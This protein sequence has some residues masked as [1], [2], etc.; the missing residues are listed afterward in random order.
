[1]NKKSL[2]VII[3]CVMVVLSSIIASIIFSMTNDKII[4]TFSSTLTNSYNKIEISKGSTLSIDKYSETAEGYEF[5]GWYTDSSLENKVNDDYIFTTNKTL[6]AGFSKIINVNQ[7]DNISSS[8]IKS[9]TIVSTNQSEAVDNKH[10]NKLLSLGVTRIDLSKAHL[11]NQ[12]TTST[13]FSNSNINEVIFGS[14]VKSLGSYTFENCYNLSNVK[15]SSSIS[16]IETGCFKNCKNLSTVKLL[17]GLLEI[18][19]DVF[20]GCSKISE[21]NIPS[22]VNNIY[23]NFVSNSSKLSRID[24]NTNNENYTSIDGVLYSKD[25]KRV[26]KCPQT[27]SGEI[28]MDSNVEIIE[29]YAFHKSNINKVYFPTSLKEIR[30]YAFYQNKNLKNIQ[31]SSVNNYLLLSSAFEDCTN[32]ET[33]KF[34]SGIQHLGHNCFKNNQSLTE[35]VILENSSFSSIGDSVFAECIKLKEISLPDSLTNI[36]VNA[37]YNC[38]RLEYVSIG[39]G[40]RE[41]ANRLFYNCENLKTINLKYSVIQ[42]GTATF[43]NCKNL[44][45]IIGI[46]YL[47]NAGQSSFYNCEKLKSISIE[48]LKSVP[49]YMFYNCK[50]LEKLTILDVRSIGEFSFAGCSSLSK[51]TFGSS[52]LEFQ[53]NSFDGTKNLTLNIIGNSLFNIVDNLVLNSD[54]TVLYHVNADSDKNEIIIPKQTS[55]IYRNAISSNHYLKNIKVDDENNYFSSNNGVLLSYNKEV[56]YSYPSGKSEELFIIPDSVKIIKKHSITSENL[57]EIIVHNNVVTIENGAMSYIPNLQT[58]TLP[59][60]GTGKQNDSQ[61]WISAIFSNSENIDQNISVNNG[62]YLPQNLKIVNITNETNISPFA[63][64]NADKIEKITYTSLVHSISDYAFA[65]CTSLT[66]IEFKGSIMSIGAY[67]FANCNKINM[68]TLGYNAGIIINSSALSSIGKS[69]EIYV[70]YDSSLL[71]D[72]SKRKTYKNKFFG[73]SANSRQWKWYFNPILGE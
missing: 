64:Y 31:I 34:G 15:L 51:L 70:N 2:F 26:I 43:Y 71:V 12:K 4:L 40:I 24:V 69:V 8:N 65:G 11:K 30:T 35:V 52:L 14:G 45:E 17:E 27:K 1:M 66:Q 67:A 25:L 62:Y 41:L 33:I 23:N 32:I 39:N 13:M 46:D 58:I 44:E 55:V 19:D 29:D 61:K 3:A 28:L 37:F 72:N 18:Q 73:V 5:L 50:S 7:I 20:Y 57:K 16:V 48:N 68:I 54:Q 60:V 10:I 21:I 56:L 6:Y 38:S 49:D 36:G 47:Q 42:V 53:E 63:F 59:F 22:T 9:Y